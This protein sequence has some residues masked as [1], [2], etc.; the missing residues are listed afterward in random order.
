M[1]SPKFILPLVDVVF[2]SLGGVLACMTQMVVI[3]AIPVE[4]AK[5]GG[6][7]TVVKHEKFS[8]L[9][10]SSEG[11]TLDGKPIS[12]EEIPVKV[13]H[14]TVVLRV[15]KNLPAQDMLKTLADL[16]E[17]GTQ[18]SLEVEAKGYKDKVRKYEER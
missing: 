3:H 10:L 6:G 13:A 14:R 1:Q 11:M 9:T 18:V 7:A 5:V 4:V 15:S 2:L 8:I 17:A 12:K 16:V